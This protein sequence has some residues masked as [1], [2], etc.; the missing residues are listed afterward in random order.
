MDIDIDSVGQNPFVVGGDDGKVDDNDNN[1]GKNAKDKVLISSLI[2]LSCATVIALALYVRGPATRRRRRRNKHK[3]ASDGAFPSPYDINTLPGRHSD[4]TD[5]LEASDRYLSQHRPDLFQIMSMNSGNGNKNSNNGRNSGNGNNKSFNNTT[6]T[7]SNM[8]GNKFAQSLASMDGVEYDD[9]HDHEDYNANNDMISGVHSAAA[10]SGSLTWWTKLTSSLRHHAVLH[11]QP[12]FVESTN[13]VCDEDP[14]A[15]PFAFS[16]FPRHDGTPCLIY[17]ESADGPATLMTQTSS[18]S[19]SQSVQFVSPIKDP[20]SLVVS[21]RAA[22]SDDE[23]QQA[24]S[25]HDLDT[26]VSHHHDHDNDHDDDDDDADGIYGNHFRDN[27]FNYTT[28]DNDD[29]YDGAAGESIEVEFTNKL[30]RLVAMRHRHYEKESIME[31]HR[32]IRRRERNKAEAYERQ[33]RLRRHEMELD[34]S[35]IEA[36]VTP[37]AAQQRSKKAWLETPE[38]KNKINGGGRRNTNMSHRTTS[39]NPDLLRSGNSTVFDEAIADMQDANANANLN[40]KTV[41]SVLARYGPTTDDGCPQPSLAPDTTNA[42]ISP[43]ASPSASATD[44]GM[45]PK[46]PKVHQI[47]PSVLNYSNPNINANM[48]SGLDDPSDQPSQPN[49]KNKHH[50]RLS[51]RRSFSHGTIEEKEGE[52][53]SNGGNNNGN[54]SSNSNRHRR[55]DSNEEALM[56]FGIAAYTMT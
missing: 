17:S 41:A 46:S 21:V 24:L 29:P 27:D 53:K 54:S 6:G 16:D 34:L 2:L 8:S 50:K 45:P 18:Q 30:E 36:T 31:K 15:Y 7:F 12:R 9:D 26:S 11:E 44:K 38:N 47:P 13:L 23:F 51:H 25:Q 33:L 1:N 55:Q 14:G 5:I 19:A 48:S 40:A 20:P 22:L 52:N 56:T 43:S 3:Q 28:S 32:E 39:S 49:R 4:A 35:E 37:T 10:G 42:S